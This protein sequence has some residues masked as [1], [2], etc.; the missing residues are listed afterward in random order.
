MA[1]LLQN[2][3]QLLIQV[4]DVLLEQSAGL[5]VVP[6]VEIDTIS[7]E[8]INTESIELVSTSAILSVKEK[9]SLRS[10]K[11]ECIINSSNSILLARAIP[12][13]IIAKATDTTEIKSVDSEEIES[14]TDNIF[15]RSRSQ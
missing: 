8:L 1:I 13:P 14:L 6:S 4:N 7:I 11:T 2:G 15:I 5:V 12:F 10:I 3:D 9:A